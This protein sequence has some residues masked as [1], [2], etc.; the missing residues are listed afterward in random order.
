MANKLKDSKLW[1]WA[2]DKFPDIA[3]KG[4]ELFGD[5]TGRESVYSIN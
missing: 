5:L 3:G 1:V 2:K 4:L